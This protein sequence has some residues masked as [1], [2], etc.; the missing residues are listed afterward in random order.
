VGDISRRARGVKEWTWWNGLKCPT[1]Q[2]EGRKKKRKESM[3]IEK[4]L[5]GNKDKR[6]KKA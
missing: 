1:T 2:L 4:V 6:K 3:Y 5:E